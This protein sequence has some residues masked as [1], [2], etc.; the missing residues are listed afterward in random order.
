MQEEVKKQARR[1]KKAGKNRG[2]KTGKRR[3]RQVWVQRKTGKWVKE[4]QTGGG[5]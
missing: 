2:V 1:W 4:V 3:K 5:G